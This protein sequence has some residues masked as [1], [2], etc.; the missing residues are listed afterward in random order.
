MAVAASP[1]SSLSSPP[2]SRDH[3]PPP[4]SPPS[5]PPSQTPASAFPKTPPHSASA[6]LARQQQEKVSPP[7]PQMPPPFPSS[8][9]TPPPTT[10]TECAATCYGAT[11]DAWRGLGYGCPELEDAHD[12]DCTGCDCVAVPP[13]SPPQHPSLPPFLPIGLFPPFSPMFIT[14]RLIQLDIA[15]F[16][17]DNFKINFEEAFIS[18]IAQSAAVGP[19][20]VQLQDI[21]SGSVV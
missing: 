14:C 1:S 2:P 6:P 21:S 12:C 10:S 11:C 17:D 7:K 3:L 8:P 9:P 20:Y 18:E 16:D 4:R 13:S 15:Q 19:E 5:N